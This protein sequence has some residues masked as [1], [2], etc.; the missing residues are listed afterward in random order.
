M[1]KEN[2]ILRHYYNL[3]IVLCISGLEYMVL[4]TDRT[5]FGE[6][7][8]HKLVGMLILFFYEMERNWIYN[9]KYWEKHCVWPI[10]WVTGVYPGIWH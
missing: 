10:A 3:F 1:K 6:A 5:V 7:F 2:N 9:E 4:R 8:I